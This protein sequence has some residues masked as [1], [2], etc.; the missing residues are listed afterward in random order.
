MFGGGDRVLSWEERS[1]KRPFDPRIIQILSLSVY[2]IVTRE[3][4]S[5]NQ[6]YST[7]F[8]AILFGMGLELLISKFYYKKVRFP[9]SSIIIALACCVLIDANFWWVYL[10]SVTLALLNKSFLTSAGRHFI[11]PGNF[12]TV[13]VLVGFSSFATGSQHIMGPEGFGF[14]LLFFVLGTFNVI[15]AR[16]WIVSFS[17]LFFYSIIGLLRIFVG[18]EDPIVVY[19]ILLSPSILLFTFHMVSDPMTT[20]SPGKK[21][22]LFGACIAGLEFLFRSL[23]IP[24]GAFYSLFIMCFAVP[25]MRAGYTHNTIARMATVPL[26]LIALNLTLNVESHKN[27]DFSLVDKTE[28]LGIEFNHIHPTTPRDVENALE[29]DYQEHDYFLK[30]VFISSG[31]AVGDVN[32]DGWKDFFLASSNPEINSQLYINNKGKGFKE[33]AIENGIDTRGKDLFPTHPI[34][35]DYNEDGNEDL[36]VFGYGCPHLYEFD[37][38]AFDKKKSFLFNE[39]S[40]PNISSVTLWDFDQDGDLDLFLTRYH[41]DFYLL[42]FRVSGEKKWNENEHNARNGGLNLVFENLGGGKFV[43]RSDRIVSNLTQWSLA[44]LALPDGTLYIAND[45]GPDQVI[46]YDKTKKEFSDLD[47]FP[48]PDRHAGMGVSLGS[49]DNQ[50]MLYISNIHRSGYLH[51]GNF[52]WKLNESEYSNSAMDLKV[53]NCRWSWGSVFADFNVDGKED[54]Y[55]SNGHVTSSVNRDLVR[56]NQFKLS[57][58]S[59]LPRSFLNKYNLRNRVEGLGEAQRD[60]LFINEDGKF[61]DVAKAFDSI[62][63]WDGRA[64]VTIDYDNDGDL[65][66]LVSPYNG[67]ARFL[68]NTSEINK[69]W[70]GFNVSGPIKNIRVHGYRAELMQSGKKQVRFMTG[71]LTGFHSQSDQRLFFG[72]QNNSKVKLVLYKGSKVVYQ[73]DDIEINKYHHINLEKTEIRNSPIKKA[74]NNPPLIERVISSEN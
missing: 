64:A 19:G 58:I 73:A 46:E 52:M 50:P 6:S 22:I 43:D 12:G 34:F 70:V 11:N 30:I 14:A 39:N 20:P 9:F 5:F 38:K 33:I 8:T 29:V 23:Y 24:N 32:N 57:N 56:E 37:G 26:A 4:F 31:I 41:K 48:F 69:R 72:L 74:D 16:Q 40:C 42:D 61:R 36:I 66:L 65:D 67:P 15:Y 68:E 27:L 7:V 60:C 1:K 18:G 53:N 44:S 54:L 2:T 45:W 62:K 51:K 49:V 13:M 63:I 28:E 3:F 55:V 59:S 21:A 35:F 17:W 71:G 10:I 25:F 47:L